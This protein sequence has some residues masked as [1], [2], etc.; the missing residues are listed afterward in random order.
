MSPFHVVHRVTTQSS[1]ARGAGTSPLCRDGRLYRELVTVTV[2]TPT[3]LPMGRQEKLGRRRPMVA[4]EIPILFFSYFLFFFKASPHK[5]PQPP[6]TP[7]TARQRTKARGCPQATAL[8]RGESRPDAWA[9]AVR[10]RGGG[11]V[12]EGFSRWKSITAKRSAC[13]MFVKALRVCSWR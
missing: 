9:R 7:L 12:E 11:G 5:P 6:P 8:I 1:F 10:K 13:Q 3:P 4:N 2:A